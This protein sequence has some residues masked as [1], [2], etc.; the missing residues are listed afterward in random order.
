MPQKCLRLI[1][2]LFSLGLPGLLHA[3]LSNATVKGTVTDP[4][5]SVIPRVSVALRNTGTGEHWEKQTTSE[6]AFDFPALSPGEYEVKVSAPGFADWTG[7][8]TLRVG[9]QAVV[10]PQMQTASTRTTIT[11]ADVT[12]IINTDNGSISDVKE[13]ERIASLPV[14][15]RNFLN[16]LNFTPGVV[17]NSFAGQGSGYTRVNGIPGGSMDY[18]VDGMT[19]VE[20]YTN[21]LQRLPQPLPTIQELKV[22]TS[23]TSAEYSRPGMVEV[24]TKSGANE[25]HGQLFEL[26]Q[27]NALAAKIFHQE[28]VNFLVHNEF[29][30]NF[31]GP[32]WIPKLYNGKNKTFFFVDAESVRQ[33]AAAS[34]RY[35]VPL[36]SW[37][38]GNFSNFVDNTGNPVI[39]YDPLTTSYNA[40]TGS[41]ARTPFPGNIIPQNRQNPIAQKVL[42]AIP[43]PNVNT[44]Y[45][46][47]QNYQNP[48]SGSQDKNT[49][50]TAKM[51]QILGINRLAARYTYTDRSN[52]GPGYLLNPEDRLY[53]GNNGAISFTESISPSIINEVRAGVQYFHAYRGP[54]TI[55]PPITSTLGLPTYPGT[56]A[57]PSFYFDSTYTFDGVDRDNPQDAPGATINFADNLSWT[58]GQHELKFG[59]F[60]QHSAVNTLRRGNLVVTTNFWEDSQDSW[61]RQPRRKAFITCR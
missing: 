34:E 29:G 31:S 59:F 43:N 61:I 44:P 13:A 48:N 53:G 58:R 16:I 41:Y 3:Q 22:D 17:S 24:V 12:P 52:F 2:V 33:S 30:G 5:S 51:D 60:F 47:G 11:V 32:V 37:K 27:G 45:Y 15:N 18:Q 36:Q 20:R 39:M 1:A 56:V 54:Q 9:Q 25:F 46:L 35:T 14:Q 26:Y 19:A 10:N 8:L 40:A 42:S 4:S 21:E 57:W 50:V 55:T 49:F 28:S 6:G 7:K 38:Q 23:N